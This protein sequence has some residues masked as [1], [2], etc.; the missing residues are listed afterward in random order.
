MKPRL[1]L[2]FALLTLLALSLAGAAMAEPIAS[3]ASS[4][5]AASPSADSFLCSLS[6]TATTPEVADGLT[7]APALKTGNCGPCSLSPCA[8]ATIGNFC[9]I[10][11]RHGTCQNVYGEICTGSTSGI[12]KCQ[13]WSGPLP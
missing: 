3:P 8:G 10:G 11:T 6:Q 12:N 9:Q 5:A 4:V 2:T 1:I 7:P 13:C